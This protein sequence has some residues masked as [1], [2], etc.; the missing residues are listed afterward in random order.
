MAVQ[1]QQCDHSANAPLAVTLRPLRREDVR[2][3]VEWDQNPTVVRLMG[4]RFTGLT[5]AWTWWE[6]MGARQG[7]IAFG[8]FRGDQ[9]VGDLELEHIGWRKAEAELRICIGDPVHWGQGV[10]SSAWGSSA[11][12]G[13]LHY[14]FSVMGLSRL[15]LRVT[16]DN[17]RA[18]NLYEKFGFVKRAKLPATGRLQKTTAVWLMELTAVYYR[19]DG[20]IARAPRAGLGST[21]AE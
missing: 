10:G 2:Q 12:A 3:L 16:V 14:A 11:P 13:L 19:G 7:R 18:V 21:A 6:G 5:D 9:L 17:H 1:W 8:I 4:R 15:Y 20:A